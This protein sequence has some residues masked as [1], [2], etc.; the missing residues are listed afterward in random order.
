MTRP[1]ALGWDVL[2]GLSMAGLLLPEAVAYAGIAGLPPVAG[3]VG[4]GVG[5]LV[6]ALLGSSRYALVA[7]TSSSAIVL[8]SAVHS[9]HAEHAAHAA[10]LAAGMVLAAGLLF[11][12]AGLLRL[13][14]LAHFIA[15]PVVRGLAFAL[16]LVIVIRQIAATAG[17]HDPAANALLLLVR[18]LRDY[19]QWNP[20]ALALFGGALAALIASRRVRLLP[21]SLLVLAASIPAA[22]MLTARGAALPRVGAMSFTGLSPGIPA[23]AGEEWLRLGELAV[24]LVLIL[25]AESYGSIRS[26]ALQHGDVVRTDRDLLA[27]GVANLLSGLCHGTAVGAGYSASMANASAGARTRLAGAAAAVFTAAAALAATPWIARIPE[28]ALAAVIVYALRHA[29][30]AGALRAYFRWRRD[31]L[32]VVV[33]VSAVLLL[34]ALDGLLLS[35]AASLVLLVQGLARDRVTALGRLGDGHDYLPLGV[36]A[37]VLPPPGLV[38]LRPEEPLFFANASVV[39]EHVVAAAR[40]PECTRGLVLSLEESPDLDSTAIEAL[41][42]CAHTIQSMGRAL[43]LARLKPPVLE[44]LSAAGLPGLSACVRSDG[45][46][47][48]VVAQMTKESPAA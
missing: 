1:A 30:D 6:Y 40:N 3:L 20:P 23:L 4:A 31:R 48:T 8:A 39:M 21:T 34:G 29:L 35:M 5:P 43:G 42:Q 44:L 45:S 15:R 28:A 41:E 27:I 36:H 16:A 22:D 38:V 13:G 19:A 14:R 33:A 25:F 11:A 47:A 9:L 37:D 2:A 18:T 32:V 17:V 12:L 10:A 46:V 24:A 26:L 7:A